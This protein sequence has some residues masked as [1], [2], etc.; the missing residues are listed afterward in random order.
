[1]QDLIDTQEELAKMEE[2][3]CNDDPGEFAT[4]CLAL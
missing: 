2:D 4:D 1:M 3:F